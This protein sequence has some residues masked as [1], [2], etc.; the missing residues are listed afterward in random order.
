MQN[1][2]KV[3]YFWVFII[4]LCSN[5]Q[6]T[7]AQ[8]THADQLAK[9]WTDATQN[10]ELRLLNDQL[11]Q[12]FVY[13]KEDLQFGGQW[14]LDGKKLQLKYKWKG[15]VVGG[16][17][18]AD[19]KTPEPVA[20]TTPPDTLLTDSL[21]QQ[22][23]TLAQQSRP[24]PVAQPNL[25][26]PTTLTIQKI[27]DT[28]LELA[29]SGATYQLTGTTES[30]M[31]HW[32]NNVWRAMLGIVFLLGI[33]Y[34]LSDN[35]KH[36]D[37]KL[38]GIGVTLQLVFAILVL[39]VDA[40][41]MVFQFISSIFVK[42][43]EYTNAGTS[44]LFASFL[45]GNIEGPF[46]NFAFQVLPT[47]VFFAAF[48]SILFY[49]GIL[50]KIVKGIAWGLSSLMRLSG[51]ESLAA[52]ANV[53]IGQTEAPF[54]VKPY[55]EKMTRSEIMCLMTGGMATIAGGVFAA[56][57]GFLGGD[58]PAQQLYFATHLLSASIMSAPAAIVA[59]KILVPETNFDA[60]KKVAD[61]PKTDIGSNL[62]DAVTAGTTDGLRLA[63]N[64][65]A[66]LLVFLAL[67]AMVDSILYDMI[68][69]YTG[70]NEAISGMSD[71][72][73]EGLKLKYIFGFL[74][75]PVAWMLGV[76]SYDIVAI[77]QLLGEKTIINEFV[78][79]ASM[80]G[81]K[82]A[83]TLLSEKSLIIATY[84]LCGF[85]NFGSIGIQIGGIGAIAPGQRK[86]LS[87]LGVM[88]LV[89]GTI[90]AFMTAV[91]AGMLIG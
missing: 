27:S 23:D 5:L 41:R 50:Q 9:T 89:G 87:E 6:T 53:F 40:V 70:I 79:Y 52:A 44:F 49:L 38:V 54:V 47:I 3:H 55:L 36:I 22:A 65:G 37:W 80:G 72:K 78:A 90:A 64:V 91:I 66:M 20:A 42:I 69:H 21:A 45:T 77:G 59:A 48:S 28:E 60:A 46:I 4:L 84:A 8:A 34:L 2:H 83:G 26:L 11:G 56:Y 86:N 85:A 33:A 24:P 14:T 63:V 7:I 73:Y 81:M 39:K 67:V 57:I 74:F 71:G 18:A 16:T 58:D 62:L 43:L 25:P 68:G 51:A 1:L 17:A 88:A 15:E 61:I 32:F 30:A 35:R 75:A 10:L 31:A 12:R 29:G 82:E 76:P 19:T 13:Q